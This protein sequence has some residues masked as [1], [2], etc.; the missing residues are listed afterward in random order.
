MLAHVTV[1]EFE[2]TVADAFHKVTVV[3][4]HD[5]RA[6]VI[7][8]GSF[9]DVLGADIEVVGRLIE[10]QEIIRLK[11]QLAQRQPAS[12]S[13]A[14]HLHFF[15]DV[16]ATEKERA[17]Q[18]PHLLAHI[19]HGQLVD[20]FKNRLLGIELLFLVLFEVTHEHAVT[21]RHGAFVL[22]AAGWLDGGLT[23][24][25]EKFIIDVEGLA[26]SRFLDGSGLEVTGVELGEEVVGVVRRLPPGALV[27]RSGVGSL[28]ALLEEEPTDPRLGLDVADAELGEAAPEAL[29]SPFGEE[30]IAEGLVRDGGSFTDRA[31]NYSSWN[32]LMDE[33]QYQVQRWN[34]F[35]A[36]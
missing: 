12:L 1:A 27:I 9:Q 30:S 24:S 4:H 17:E 36:A 2:E 11:Q 22:H 31:C 35:L 28:L 26:M 6:F 15:V 20:R 3:A 7:M 33:Q 23:G 21:Q 16:I 29:D 32:S 14:Q 5:H 19:A 13:P 25:F 34:E 18:S 8:D 10:Q